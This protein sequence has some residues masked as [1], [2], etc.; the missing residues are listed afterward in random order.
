MK[1]VLVA[2]MLLLASSLMAHDVYVKEVNMP[3]DKLYPKVLQSLANHKLI[4]VSEIDILDK[5]KHAGLPKKFGKKF[6]TNKLTGIKAI[7]A[8]NGFFG[9]EVANSDPQMMALCPVRITMIEKDGKSQMLFARPSKSSEGTKAHK[10]LSDLE[11]KVIKALESA[12]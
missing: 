5:F 10:A 4:V 11:A 1:K 12:L 9:N 3:L 7:I 6:N 2:L 8:C